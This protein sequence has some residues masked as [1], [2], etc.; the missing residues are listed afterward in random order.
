MKSIIF[1]GPDGTGKNFLALATVQRLIS[2]GND[3]LMTNFPQYFAFG[4][5]IREMNRGKAN[6]VF[7]EM[8]N[9]YEQARHRAAMYSMDR[10]LS[11]LVILEYRKTHPD[12][13][14]ISDRGPDSNAVTAGYIWANNPNLSEADLQ[15]FIDEEI[16]SLD[17]EFRALTDPTIFLCLESNPEN[18][19]KIYREQLDQLESPSAQQRAIEIYSKI[20]PDDIIHTKISG[21]W[22]SSDDLT[23]EVISRCPSDIS[24]PQKDTA[25]GNLFLVGPLETAATLVKNIPEY[26]IELDKEW[27]SISLSSEDTDG[28]RKHRLDELESKIYQSLSDIILDKSNLRL[29]FP[30]IVVQAVKRLLSLYPN[31][32]QI[33]RA[34]GGEPFSQLLTMICSISTDES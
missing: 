34:V 30:I 29:N 3:V 8:D 32:Q 25:K 15:R 31:L 21:K 13:I 2:E 28:L 9:P 23:D 7:T 18:S 4:T 11:I 24:K 20:L 26:F 14:H 19:G 33:I 27:R 12:A 22:R 10:A 6:T 17:A 5:L 1:E 16:S